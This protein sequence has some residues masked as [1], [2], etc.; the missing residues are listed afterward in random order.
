MSNGSLAP[1]GFGSEHPNPLL[2]E[3]IVLRNRVIP[4][5]REMDVYVSNGGYEAAR[6]ALTTMQPDAVIDVVKQSGLRGRGGA[7][8]PTGTKW[9]FIPKDI[10]PKY[11]VCNADE[12]EPGTFNNHEI[13]Y[14]NPHQLI[15]GMIISGFA[16][17]ASTGYIYIRGEYAYGAVVLEQ[18][19]R[20]AY[21]R[22][23]LG[24]NL[25]GG[26]FSFDLYVHRGAGAYICGEETALLESLEG[27]IGQPRLR[28]PFP[29]VK[30]LYA[31]PTVVNNVQTLTNVPMILK[32][33][34]AWYKQFGTEKSPGT[35][36]ISIS[37]HVKRPGNYEVPLGTTLRQFIYDVAGGIRNDRQLKFVV[38]GG[39]STNWLINKPE[40]LDVPLAW[41]DM[42]AIGTEL[43]S[44]AVIV[45]DE[46]T[47]TV[48]AAMKIDEFFK[49]ESCGKCTPC[50][51]GTHFLTKVWERIEHGHGRPGDIMLLSD[52]GREI[53]SGPKH[54][55]FCL[56]GPSSVSAVNSAIKYF[57][58][59]IQAHIDQGRCPLGYTHAIPRVS[60]AEGSAAT[61]TA[62]ALVR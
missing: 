19:I 54:N 33:G 21:A 58:D 31:L 60:E 26:N 17:G 45:L 37:G 36:A 59:E 61:G 28:P 57:S 41:D 3:Y 24:K 38:P 34:A 50:R 10:F 44:G 30:G 25:W 4:N 47:C 2:Q 39:A 48:A 7:G 6:T 22:G 42:R 53:G 40:H 49:H 27:K 51:E 55:C 20:E 29:A 52:V 18:A 12:S 32:N 15:E 1:N 5:I 16:V 56:L 13:I 43:G 8:F 23:F 62:P 46:T 11:L 9:S 35:F 14:Y